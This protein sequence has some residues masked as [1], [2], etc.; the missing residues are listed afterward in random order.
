[1]TITK[2]D[3]ER[4]YIDELKTCEEIGLIYGLTQSGVCYWK[5][6]L[7]VAEIKG[8]RKYVARYRIALTDEVKQILLGSMLG[9]GSISHHQN[10][11]YFSNRHS[12]KQEEYVLWKAKKLNFI[13]TAKPVYYND[14]ATGGEY[15]R[16]FSYKHPEVSAMR[17]LWYDDAGL[18]F[19]PAAIVKNINILGLAGWYMDDGFRARRQ[20]LFATC[21]FIDAE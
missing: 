7:G 21:S 3:F 11:Y 17:P 15:V 20:S 8:D 9:D 5:R 14:K 10:G 19:V 13:I 6:K 16:V 18:K 12:I 4:L 2:E 1:M